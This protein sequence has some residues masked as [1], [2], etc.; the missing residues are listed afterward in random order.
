MHTP[1]GRARR[2]YKRDRAELANHIC[3]WFR[4]RNRT[5]PK[6]SLIMSTSGK[7]VSLSERRENGGQHGDNGHPTPLHRPRLTAPRHFFKQP[8]PLAPLH[9]TTPGGD[10]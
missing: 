10:V 5:E 9:A 2:E 4:D 1:R 7:L 3:A 8:E 6:K